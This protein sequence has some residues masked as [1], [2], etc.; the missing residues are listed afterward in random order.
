MIELRNISKV[1]GKGESA[2]QAISHLD[3]KIEKS[4]FLMVV[5]PSGSGKSTLLNLIGCMDMPTEGE[6]Y[7]EGD[8]ILS[9]SEDARARFR[10]E[11]IGFV[12]Q[13][14]QLMPAL[15]V[16]E[17]VALPFLVSRKKVDD[18]RIMDLLERLEIAEK[19]NSLPGKLSGGQQQRVAMARAMV[20][21]PALLLADEPTGN[22]DS[23][24][25]E[26]VIRLMNSLKTPEQTI[27]MI[28]HNEKLTEHADRV[29]RMRD[30]YVDKEV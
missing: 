30:G 17:N 8:S 7:Y 29:V 18:R 12:F 25:G 9:L 2:C 10:N 15:S 13:N 22:L 1:Y 26:T 23:V 4:E 21:Q 3:L 27:V 6:I 14:F 5:G 11:K 19:S 20:M 24:T 28:T 16:Y